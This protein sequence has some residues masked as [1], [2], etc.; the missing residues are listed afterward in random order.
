[1]TRDTSQTRGLADGRVDGIGPITIG[2]RRALLEANLVSIGASASWEGFGVDEFRRLGDALLSAAE[3]R[4]GIGGDLGRGDGVPEYLVPVEDVLASIGRTLAPEAG[5]MHAPVVLVGCGQ[6]GLLTGLHRLVRSAD[7]KHVFSRRLI[8]IDRGVDELSFLATV[9]P[10]DAVVGDDAVTWF[11]GERCVERFEG[12]LDERGADAL[13]QRV[14]SAPLAEGCDPKPRQKLG[15][16]VAEVLAQRRRAQGNALAQL[17]HDNAAAYAGTT[18]VGAR[19]ALREAS[20]GERSLRVLICTTR[21]STYL[22]H[23][24][25]GLVAALGGLG[26][27][28]ELLIERDSSSVFTQV[29]Y[30]EAVSD[31]RPDLVFILNYTRSM[32][33]GALP[34]NVPV[35]TWIQDAM[36]HLLDPAVGAATTG[37][38]LYAGSAMPELWQSF[39]FRSEAAVCFPVTACAERF[40]DGPVTDEQ[41]RRFACDV[42]FVSH[43]SKTPDELFADIRRGFGGGAVKVVDALRDDAERLVDVA[44]SK[45][46]RGEA[47]RSVRDVFCRVAGR[48]PT[49]SE[50]SV[51][52]HQVVAPLAGRMIR[53]RVLGWAA[54]ICERRGWSFRVFGNGWEDCG[55]L[56]RF[57][58]GPIEHGADLRAAYRAAGVH[59]HVDTNTLTH[60]RVFECVLSGGFVAPWLSVDTLAPAM[61]RAADELHELG[62]V[63]SSRGDGALV[64]PAGVGSLAARVE[65]EIAAS[66]LGCERCV[67]I[68]ESW[69][70][71]LLGHRLLRDRLSAP[72]DP[73]H[74]LGGVGDV[75]FVDER[76]LE[77]R[78]EKAIADREWRA[79]RAEA[80]RS[81]VARHCTTEAFAKLVIEHAARFLLWREI[82]GPTSVWKVPTLPD[83]RAI[84]DEWE[85]SC[86]DV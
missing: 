26:H 13:P 12:W 42:A 30:A 35:V 61:T 67:A 72:F 73:I 28:A 63:A 78:L 15:D 68:D 14:F 66:G 34:P 24:A 3:A 71:T 23:A 86:A 44:T 27:D 32:C 85:G 38:D 53:H 55:G 54:S 37:W 48:E 62:V 79:R 58:A 11:V 1:M 39:G 81:G 17:E 41:R 40:H 18:P 9:E 77:A 2:E 5:G 21:H 50:A 16:E 7:P 25:E 74:V 29:S 31:V 60:Q 20:V 51:L 76:T 4:C 22:R 43:H 47:R 65:S 36:A 49:E 52:F 82:E 64:F 75:G 46:L 8:V 70:P 84:Y 59:L 19:E 6:P 33:G 45:S 69:G 83:I 80:M 57:A 10:I 56:S